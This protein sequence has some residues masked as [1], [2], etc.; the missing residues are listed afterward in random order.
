MDLPSSL[1]CV[2]PNRFKPKQGR[3]PSVTGVDFL[4]VQ[5]EIG[6]AVRSLLD[7]TPEL[8]GL[9]RGPGDRKQTAPSP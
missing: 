1:S 4:D 3:P 9:V 2:D 5:P 8:R 6:M 7:R